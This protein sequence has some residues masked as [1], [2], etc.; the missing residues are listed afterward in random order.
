MC[1]SA[2][3][4]PIVAITMDRAPHARVLVDVERPLSGFDPVTSIDPGFIPRAGEPGVLDGGP[5][6]VRRLNGTGWIMVDVV[7]VAV[8]DLMCSYSDA[9]TEMTSDESYRNAEW[10]LVDVAYLQ[11]LPEFGAYVEPTGPSR[12]PIHAYLPASRSFRGYPSRIQV[13]GELLDRVGG[14]VAPAPTVIVIKAPQGYGKS[15]LARQLASA[16]DHNAGWFLAAND[17]QTLI[18][19]L[20]RAERTG[21]AVP[22]TD[23][24]ARGEKPDQG[25]NQSLAASALGRLR[26]ALAPWVVVLDNC[27]Q[28]PR[29]TKTGIWNLLPVPRVEGQ[30]LIVTTT[31]DAWPPIA[32]AEGWHLE[33]LEPLEAVDLRE[34]RLPKGVDEVVAGRPLIA[35]SLAGLVAAGARIQLDSGLDGPS[36]MW[37]LFR[38]A[39]QS[40]EA[41]RVARTLAWCPP[42]GI[43][44]A[45][46]PGAKQAGPEA[47]TVLVNA[48]L[49]APQG[50]SRAREVQMHRLIAAAIRDQTW[51]DETVQ[52]QEAIRRV[53]LDEDGRLV[54]LRASDEAALTRLEESEVGRAAEPL[55]Q[56][57]GRLWHAL[58]HIR[59]RRGPIA[60]SAGLFRK[61]L[62]SLEEGANAE[63]YAESLMG[64]ARATYQASKDSALL[65]E[66]GMQAAR[67][68]CILEPFTSLESRQMREQANALGLLIQQKIAEPDRDLTRRLDRLLEIRDGLWISYE[69]R[70]AIARP[71][72]SPEPKS[73]PTWEDG[74]GS[75]RAFYNLAGIN[76]QI[77]KTANAISPADSQVDEAF[78]EA[79]RVYDAVRGL[80]HRR[81][82]GRPHPHLASCVH[83]LAIV[84]Y[85]RALFGRPDADLISALQFASDALAQRSAVVVGLYGEPGAAVHDTDVGKSVEFLIKA[86]FLADVTRVDATRNSGRAHALRVAAEALDEYDG[87]AQS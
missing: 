38:E 9:I 44:T 63:A 60:L 22:G 34:L 71:E 28:D 20:A 75:E 3:L 54:L 87:A 17:R 48:G 83:G 79:A 77:A 70:R 55:S 8:G 23:I 45:R 46:V 33:E 29:D 41:V 67:A 81:Y 43:E 56:M 65:R 39:T 12:P 30:T 62:E 24:A 58:G 42:E 66:A 4:R 11:S 73:P 76:L 31:H 85:Y 86:S 5:L 35:E 51:T 72:V 1:L 68:A 80:R 50:A 61:A 6:E 21:R 10:S 74:L 57:S 16:A 7:R 59:E 13:V 40:P 49:V 14:R 84:T 25:E 37:S 52:A 2:D 18:S 15:L 82:A 26:D 69:A 47:C 78:Q 64:V 53:V 36:M 19:S 32:R 27:D